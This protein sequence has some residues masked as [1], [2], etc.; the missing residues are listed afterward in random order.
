MRING[1][2]G[3]DNVQNAKLYLTILKLHG[4][5]VENIMRTLNVLRL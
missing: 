3:V 5:F 2:M 4:T 1:K